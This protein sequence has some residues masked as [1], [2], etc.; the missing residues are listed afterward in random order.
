MWIFTQISS[1]LI[2]SEMWEFGSSSFPHLPPLS[3]PARDALEIERR[4]RKAVNLRNEARR[5]SLC[6]ERMQGIVRGL[7]LG[8]APMPEPLVWRP[9]DAEGETPR[10]LA[11]LALSEYLRR[12]YTVERNGIERDRLRYDRLEAVFHPPGLRLF[13]LLALF[14]QIRKNPL[15]HQVFAAASQKAEVSNP[16]LQVTPEECRT[17]FECRYSLI[18]RCCENSLAIVELIDVV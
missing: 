14:E 16:T 18:K 3:Q 12:F 5:Y 17:A 13:N 9:Y 7:A 8:G 10:A 15:L 6:C 1:Y 4:S 11:W 2:P